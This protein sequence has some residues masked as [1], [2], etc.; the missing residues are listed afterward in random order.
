M[1]YEV[2]DRGT[3]GASNQMDAM[4]RR[5]KEKENQPQSGSLGQRFASEFD[6]IKERGGLFK[7]QSFGG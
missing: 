6:K 2:K 3:Q 4:K 7:K 1:E 5:K